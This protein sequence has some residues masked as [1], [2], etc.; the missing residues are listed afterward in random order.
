MHNRTDL[1]A[2]GFQRAKND[3][4]VPARLD[5]TLQRQI[6]N[7]NSFALLCSIPSLFQ[8]GTRK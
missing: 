7:C 5:L 6:T 4:L 2:A 8:S 1:F 3:K